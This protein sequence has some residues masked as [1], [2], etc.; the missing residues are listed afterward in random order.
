MSVKSAFVVVSLT[1]VTTLLSAHAS[2]ARS[3]DE[4]HLDMDL[5]AASREQCSMASAAVTELSDV[6]RAARHAKDVT[7]MRT[8]LDQ[9]LSPLLAL[10]THLGSCGDIMKMLSTAPAHVTA[11]SA[12][13]RFY[14][15]E[16]GDIE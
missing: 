1:A 2:A 4:Q 14:S 3:A 5:L 8:T 9:T 16:D 12:A 13:A 7:Q 6:L 10:R 11:P 15:A